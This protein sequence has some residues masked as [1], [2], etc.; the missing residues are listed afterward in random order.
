MLTSLL[1]VSWLSIQ[2]V[3]LVQTCTHGPPLYHEVN[4]FV[5]E[6]NCPGIVSEVAGVD[7]ATVWVVQTK[8]KGKWKRRLIYGALAGAEAAVVYHNAKVF[9]D[10]EHSRR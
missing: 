2:S 5:P 1:L 7:V 4:P 8:I 3:D 10:V 9:Q 6:R